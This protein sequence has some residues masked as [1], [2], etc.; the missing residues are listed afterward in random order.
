M[1]ESNIYEDDSTLCS[2]S[3][4]VTVASTSVTVALPVSGVSVEVVEAD[5]TGIVTFDTS[6]V[7]I[8]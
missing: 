3:N 4:G 8:H 6:T 7:Y 2:N 5:S 1:S